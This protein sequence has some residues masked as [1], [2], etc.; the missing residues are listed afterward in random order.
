MLD[1]QRRKRKRQLVYFVTRDDVIH[2]IVMAGVFAVIQL[3]L[4]HVA[5]AISTAL[6]VVTGKLPALP[7]V[8][9]PILTMQLV[10]LALLVRGAFW[11]STHTEEWREMVEDATDEQAAND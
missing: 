7:R 1:K 6:A 9:V 3:G 10:L 4:R 5:E 11:A 2:G 8:T